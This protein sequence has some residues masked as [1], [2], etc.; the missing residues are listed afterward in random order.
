MPL[1]AS[2]RAALDGGL[3]FQTLNFSLFKESIMA[4]NAKQFSEW[5]TRFAGPNTTDV[6]YGWA[7]Q[8]EGRTNVA[9]NLKAFSSVAATAAQ[10][11]GS[12]F[13]RIQE[14]RTLNDAQQL[15]RAAKLATTRIK[16]VKAEFEA[17]MAP[18]VQEAGRLKRSLDSKLAAPDR[19]GDALIDGELRQLLRNMKSADRLQAVRT[20]PALRAAAARAPAA[21]SGLA[22]DVHK[23]I[24]DEYLQEVA[25]D[26]FADYTDLMQAV[27]AA[28]TA[29]GQLQEDA[30]SLIDFKTA[31]ALEKG[32]TAGM[33]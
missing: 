28:A 10:E 12:N 1:Q 27:N 33:V 13:F 30:A 4:V 6:R 7:S 5:Q 32:S 17:R 11:I 26:E 15:T 25:P 20:D 2:N 23:S 19:S 3:F 16:S 14:D 29:A 22:G 9:R 21:L 31:E 18:A 24:R 8:V